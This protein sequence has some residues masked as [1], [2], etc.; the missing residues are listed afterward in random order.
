MSKAKATNLDADTGGWSS[1]YPVSE[2]AVELAPGSVV[3]RMQVAA[4]ETPYQRA[5]RK[6]LKEDVDLDPKVI[7]SE[8][9]QE[10]FAPR[11]NEEKINQIM[12][13]YLRDNAP[14][15][16]HF[17]GDLA[18]DE[19]VALR[20]R[21][22]ALNPHLAEPTSRTIADLE[23]A[24]GTRAGP[25]VTKLAAPVQWAEAARER[26]L[27]GA[28][29]QVASRDEFDVSRDRLQALREAAA[30]RSRTV[31][32]T[33]TDERS[34][35]G[36]LDPTVFTD[37]LR[38]QRMMT[39]R[40]PES[41]WPS[42]EEIRQRTITMG[43]LLKGSGQT[44]LS[45]PELMRLKDA[46][47]VRKLE[48]RD[49]PQIVVPG[50]YLS[51]EMSTRPRH[52][53]GE[54]TTTAA[55]DEALKAALE[56]AYPGIDQT[57]ELFRLARSEKARVREAT[58]ELGAQI[59][60]LTSLARQQL[61]KQ[62]IRAATRDAF[63]GRGYEPGVP[64]PGIPGASPEA[65]PEAAPRPRVPRPTTAPTTAPTPEPTAPDFGWAEILEKLEEAKVQDAELLK[66]M[67]G[68]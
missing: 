63:P 28:G 23:E 32:L 36:R 38:A 50:S 57:P 52:F 58:E 10:E 24:L 31:P 6:R 68:E 26:A 9:R 55:H 56:G 33:V 67:G 61:T 47:D 16:V 48:L 19:E 5:L 22:V 42:D 34:E 39:R 60:A 11:S 7:S 21:V 13:D 53:G 20:E 35:M 59:N 15:G 64:A 18:P 46:L 44:S 37:R 40:I 29:H 62:E 4:D 1:E 51:T 54:L 17:V 30:K 8:I 27:H 2:P 49:I 25:V 12:R 43:D 45:L 14:R 65:P 41:E 3:R 66:R